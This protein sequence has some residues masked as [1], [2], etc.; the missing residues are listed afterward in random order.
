MQSIANYHFSE[1][2][3]KLFSK[4][5]SFVI[6]RCNNLNQV[7]DIVQE[8]FL[9]LYKV[10]EKRGIDYIDNPEAFSIRIAKFKLIKHYNVIS[11][12]KNQFTNL[13]NS[14]KNDEQ[15]EYVNE[16]YNI[17]DSYINS[18][19]IDE[20]WQFLLKKPIDTQRV[21]ALYYQS[22]LT[23]KEIAINMKKTESFVK[24]KLYRTLGEIRNI[25][26]REV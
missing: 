13:K 4:I 19:L 10:I 21:F 2:Y 18:L 16:T 26:K 9:E 7:E 12:L 25:Y 8:V 3:D 1:L 11:A 22:G 15:I 5:T 17:E 14:T 6:S 23:I 20:V 24:H